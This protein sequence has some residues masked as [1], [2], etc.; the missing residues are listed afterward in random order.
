MATGQGERFRQMRQWIVG[1]RNAFEKHKTGTYNVSRK[2]S[3]KTKRAAEQ[4]YLT[5]LP[6]F[7]GKNIIEWVEIK[8]QEHQQEAQK[9]GIQPRPVR[10]VDIG[11]GEGQALLDMAYRW[12]EKVQ[13]I[14]YGDRTIS[15]EAFEYNK[16]H[17]IAQE[18]QQAGIQQ[19]DGNIIDIDKRLR[20]VYGNNFH[21][22]IIMASFVL[23]YVG[24]FPQWKIFQRIYRTLGKGGIA[25]LNDTS[26]LL[27]HSG[28]KDVPASEYLQARG[29][30][31]ETQD[32]HEE[33]D[34]STI[35]FQRTGKHARLAPELYV[36]GIQPDEI[37]KQR[38]TNYLAIR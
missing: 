18:L 9:L 31:W 4:S 29:Y 25:F 6:E 34:T 15:E 33:T 28:D 8:I 32:Y 20:E 3:E 5:V 13:L 27:L 1:A 30:S 11:Y 37:K 14:G 16:P 24:L 38:S 10:I 7:E 2:L 26:T 36:T 23:R 35:A 22:D 17:S 12:G 19:V 21:P